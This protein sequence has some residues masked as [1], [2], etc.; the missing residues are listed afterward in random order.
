MTL[1]K[2]IGYLVLLLGVFFLVACGEQGTTVSTDTNSEE[3]R[4]EVSEKEIANQQVDLVNE[5]IEEEYIVAVANEREE[6]LSIIYFPEERQEKIQLEGQAHNLE[7]N[8]E[9]QLL[10]VTINPPH[11]HGE[12]AGHSHSHDSDGNEEH[13][14]DEHKEEKVVAYDL[15]SLEK[16]EEYSVGSHPAHV[17]VTENGQTVVV[18]NSGD[19]TVS[20]I[21]RGVGELVNVEV[22]EYP[23]GVR[24]SPDQQYAYIAN[25]QS[26]NVSV[27]DLHSNVEVKRVHVGAGA[28]QTGFSH[29]GK[30]AFVGL[31]GDDQLAVIDTSSQEL[32]N[33]IDVGKGPV[34][35]YASYDH[36]YVIVANQGSE[37]YPSDTISI[38]NLDLLQVE[39]E[40]PLGLGAHGIVIS[41]DS[42]YAFV[43][44][45]FE[46]TISVVDLETLEEINRI[47]V[48]SYPNGISVN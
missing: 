22:G 36:R 47:D 18:T 30:Y 24:I 48:G 44:N 2:N 33:K 26:E 35:M 3:N 5:D 14:H 23:H 38:I 34:Q 20:I 4:Q 6:T 19:N 29:D 10:W 12:D 13:G 21:D 15:Q 28:V 1:K 17:T 16:V 45:M 41:K 8:K 42:R 37:E 43:T 31:H 32:I 11:R 27:V 46:D 7:I 40:L 9:S 25:M 39:K